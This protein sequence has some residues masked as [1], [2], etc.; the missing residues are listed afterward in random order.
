M[1]DMVQAPAFIRGISKPRTL[2]LLYHRIN[3]GRRDPQLLSVSPTNFSQHLEVLKKNFS[4]FTTSEVAAGDVSRKVSVNSVAV[5]F[6]DGYADNLTNALPLLAKHDV[7]ATIF[8]STSFVKERRT[9]W[10]DELADTAF[11]EHEVSSMLELQ[12]Q[13][14]NQFHFNGCNSSNWVA[15]AS[16][17]D[18]T[19]NVLSTHDPT[20]R[21][22]L[23]RAASQ[24]LRDAKDDDRQLVLQKLR[25]WASAVKPL[26][27]ECQALTTMQLKELADC[28][29]IEIGSHT[30]SHPVLSRL[31]V[32]D[33]KFELSES[34]QFLEEVLHRP[35]DGF[36]YPY[37]GK[38]DY[39]ADTVQCVK[40]AGYKWAF[41]NVPEVVWN[42]THRYQL[43]RLL[44][45][46]CDGEY[47]EKWLSEWFGKGPSL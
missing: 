16:A 22:S 1:L 4:I 8:I 13:E 3:T 45:R 11:G 42:G 18:S 36:A 12:L 19:W 28:D 26:Q 35:I 44:V 37:G 39:S 29:L 24:Y 7:P 17:D 15:S 10:W 40:E 41:S 2:V 32:V 31:P 47:F 38:N 43:P 5:T 20:T 6:D 9:F 33:Q 34:K 27:A 25:E 23:Y 21:H 14:K 46:D 30:V